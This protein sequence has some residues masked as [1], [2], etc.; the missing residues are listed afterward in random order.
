MKR[1]LQENGRRSAGRGGGW[2]GRGNGWWGCVAAVVV[3][4]GGLLQACTSNAYLAA[5]EQTSV[6]DGMPDP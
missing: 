1:I 6:V 4:A 2:R 3:L 5:R